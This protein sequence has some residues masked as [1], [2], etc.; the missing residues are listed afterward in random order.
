MKNFAASL[1]SWALHIVGVLV[2][3]VMVLPLL[4]VSRRLR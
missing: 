3:L 2:V 4:V 1:G